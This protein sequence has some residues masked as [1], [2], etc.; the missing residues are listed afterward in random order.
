MGTA[1]FP[2]VLLSV[3]T[4]E[5]VFVVLELAMEEEETLDTG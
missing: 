4:V 2:L 5:E 1:S 3:L